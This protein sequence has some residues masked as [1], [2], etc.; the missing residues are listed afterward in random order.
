MRWDRSYF[1]PPAALEPGAAHSPPPSLKAHSAED[2]KK[3]L[4]RLFI[5]NISDDSRLLDQHSL[6]LG[7]PQ[8]LP[9]LSHACKQG[10]AAI[11]L[12]EAI[13]LQELLNTSAGNMQGI[14]ESSSTRKTAL[15]FC[16]DLQ[17]RQGLLAG[18]LHDHPSRE[19]AI[20]GITGSN[21]KSS[22]A[23]LVYH[24]WSALGIRAGMIGT[25]GAFWRTEKQEYF[26]ET[27][28]TSPRCWQLQE[29]LGA[30]RKQGVKRVV[31][32]ASS[33]ALD[34]GRMSGLRFHTAIFS[35]LGR[36]HMDYHKSMEAY[37]QAKKRLFMLTQDSQGRM[38]I[39]LREGDLF[40]K[41]LLQSY[42]SYAKTQSISTGMPTS[43]IAKK[44]G[45]Q[46]LAA[47]QFH[48]WNMRLALEG[49]A[50]DP[51]EKKG[52]ASLLDKADFPE[53]P[54]GRYEVLSH[55]VLR[56]TYAVV[57]Y[58]HSPEALEK[59]LSSLRKTAAFVV[60]V[61]GCGGNRD[62]GKRALMGAAASALS[63]HII[64]CDDNPR[65]EDAQQIRNDIRKGIAASSAWEE[66]PDRRAAIER[67][68][69]LAAES[70]LSPAVALIAGK[71]HENY[72]LA[73]GKKSFFSD[74]EAVQ[75]C[76]AYVKGAIMPS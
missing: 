56:D 36:D 20:V 51:E 30:M 64:L 75:K 59:I 53:F 49:A 7:T 68:I 24:L 8:G 19:L 73:Q 10:P 50:F 17:H 45:Q 34:L 46:G 52:M 13:E 55:P 23:W 65:W 37:F 26:Q 6:F 31:L 9:W 47:P 32:E 69:L 35:G 22:I 4:S 43:P 29:L 44:A 21:G 28:Y 62:R 74:K 66:I 58:A 71:G 39:G 72:Q 70:P 11:L 63:D 33:E 25:L 16:Q 15:L 14:S 61:F 60:C 38:I 18:A 2:A 5:K 41:R 40:A 3:A 57:D 54:P 1:I 76:F 48:G 42:A 67:A 27:G 12:D